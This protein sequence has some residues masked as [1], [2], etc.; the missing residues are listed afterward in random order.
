MFVSYINSLP[1]IFENIVVYLREPATLAVEL[2]N[3]KIIQCLGFRRKVDIPIMCIKLSRIIREHKVN[4]IHSHL[5]WPTIVARG[6]NISNL[7]HVFSVHTTMSCD[8]FKPNRLSK[9]LERL[10]YSKMQTAAFVSEAARR[11]YR[12]YIRGVGDTVL[13]HNFV[14][15]EFFEKYAARGSAFSKGELKLVSVGNLNHRKG[16]LLLLEA[17]NALSNYN[18]TLDIYGEGQQKGKLEKYIKDNGLT[19]VRLMGS[20][21]APETF[22]KNYDVFVL[23]SYYEGFCLAMAEAMAVGLP[24][25]VS[26]IDVLKEISGETQLY[27][28]LKNIRDLPV[29]ILQLYNMREVLSYYSASAREV[30]GRYK[31][32]VHMKKLQ[33][34]YAT[35]L[36]GA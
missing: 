10:T 21:P 27:I 1:A 8:A 28:D 34:L 23:A 18:I 36:G 35:L 17:L 6:A 26:D 9:Y 32:D 5:Y 30:A 12:K 7:P 25:I 13:L 16:H 33:Q 20:F 11:D 4:L 22:L 2:R 19:S 14:R 3:A 29:K 31:K 15:E 24:C